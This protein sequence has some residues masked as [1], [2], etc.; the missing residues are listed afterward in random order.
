[1]VRAHSRSGSGSSG[2]QRDSRARVRELVAHER[3]TGA[4]LHARRAGISERRAYE[5]L[6]AVRAGGQQP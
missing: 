1:V 3:A 4:H 2:P 6:R 5:L